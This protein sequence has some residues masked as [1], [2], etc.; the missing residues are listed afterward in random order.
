[1]ASDFPSPP[2]PRDALVVLAA[3]DGVDPP[4]GEKL[5]DAR[6][7]G[8]ESSTGDALEDAS[9]DGIDPLTG[10]ALE[11]G[12]AVRWASVVKATVLV[13]RPSVAAD[14]SSAAVLGS[15]FAVWQ[16]PVYNAMIVFT[17]SFRPPPKFKQL[18]STQCER[19]EVADEA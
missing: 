4:R 5:E 6:V 19:N 1:M 16:Y 12:S 3:A 9:A 13:D 17:S 15:I 7:D 11:D 14:G 8:M 10:N 2:E 18:L